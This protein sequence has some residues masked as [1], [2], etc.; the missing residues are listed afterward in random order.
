MHHIKW[1]FSSFPLTLQWCGASLPL[2]SLQN[3]G[4]GTD[5]CESD[6]N[7][8]VQW[9]WGSVL[10]LDLP[11]LKISN[12]DGQPVEPIQI[13]QNLSSEPLW[14]QAYRIR[15]TLLVKVVLCLRLA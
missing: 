14:F 15:F 9:S 8:R 12:L 4:G 5:Q 13:F 11:N 3:C 1:K 10:Q 2:P 6:S 7:L